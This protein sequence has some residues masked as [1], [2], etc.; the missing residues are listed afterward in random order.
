[1]TDAVIAKHKAGRSESANTIPVR[2][3]YPFFHNKKTKRAN[4]APVKQ[5]HYAGTL[6]FPKTSADPTKCANYAWLAAHCMAAAKAAWPGNVDAAG[7]WTWPA[8]GHWPIQDGDRVEAAKPPQ[9]G[10]AAAPPKEYP[11][12]KGCWIIEPTSYLEVGPKISVMQANGQAFDIPAQ[13]I[14][15]RQMYKGGDVW[16]IHLSAYSFHNEKFGVNFSFEGA[17]WCAEGEAIGSSG[18]KQSAAMFAGVANFVAP[19]NAPP[20]PPMPGMPPLPTSAPGA[21]QT[22]APQ[23]AHPAQPATVPQPMAAVAYPSNVAP[24]PG[25]AAPSYPPT[26]AVPAYAPPPPPP[27]GMAALP[28]FPGAR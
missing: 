22:Y 12:R 27:P 23:P 20:G 24:A 3:A 19:T 7:N 28:P 9:P 14:N 6:L 8:G 18:P 11:W 13:N 10:Q 1:M 25:S 16:I 21:G 15:G 17:L 5:P 26:S 2:V 4:G